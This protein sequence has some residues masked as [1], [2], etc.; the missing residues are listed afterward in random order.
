[1][2]RIRIYLYYVTYYILLYYVIYQKSVHIWWAP[3][4][5]KFAMIYSIDDPYWTSRKNSLEVPRFLPEV[6]ENVKG[7]GGCRS[8]FT[9]GKKAVSQFTCLKEQPHVLSTNHISRHQNE[10][11]HTNRY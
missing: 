5:V 3:T 6:T 11:F 10:A 8:I 1:M 7:G 2:Y 4:G 9:T